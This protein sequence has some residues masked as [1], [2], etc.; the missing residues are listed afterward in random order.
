MHEIELKFQVSASRSAALARAVATKTARHMALRAW[1]FDTDDRRLARAGLALRVRK[2]GRRWVQTLKGSGDGIWQRLE[3]EVPRQLP[4][5]ASPLADPAL[6]AGTPPGDALF[7]ALGDGQLQALY[8][9]DVKRT[10]RLLRGADCVVELAFDRGALVAGERRLPLR[11]LEFELKS[12]SPAALAALAARWVDRFDLTLDTRSKA[13]RGERLARGERLGAAVKA[14]PL[15][16]S[17]VAAA[18]VTTA[19][20]AAVANCLRQILGNASDLAHETQTDP[21]QLHQLRVGLR[22]LRTVLRELGPLSLQASAQSA[23]AWDEAAARLFRA[24]GTARD[25]DALEHT[26]LPAL[27]KAGAGGLRLP[28]PESPSEPRAALRDAATTRLWLQ[29]LAFAAPAEDPSDAVGAADAVH[30]ARVDVTAGA[31][32]DVHRLR[33]VPAPQAFAPA[34][35]ARMARLFKQVRRDAAAF[36]DLDD[37]ARHRLRKRVKRLRYL[38]EFAAPAFR[39]KRV[40]AFLRRLAP[41]QQALGHFN[42]VCVAQALFKQTA[43]DD[44][45]AMFALGWLAHERDGAIARCVRALTRLRRADVFWD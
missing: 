17:A 25:R 28:P 40:R 1:Y 35:A 24:L 30:A 18:D 20:R 16:A 19:L 29:L 22:R 38:G 45:P 36:G 34:V 23:S 3:H 43:A 11:E 32:A 41:A 42:D 12:G 6:H 26:L 44:A 7:E 21:E 27:H 33:N 10:T 9:T 5:G 39:A 2:E 8:G 15:Q 31:A 37:A 4:P 14:Q 13:E